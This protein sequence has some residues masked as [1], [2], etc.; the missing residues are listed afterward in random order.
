MQPKD[1]G[2]TKTTL[3]V[4]NRALSQTHGCAKR[5]IL[6]FFL[7]FFFL[8]LGKINERVLRETK[9]KHAACLEK[10]NTTRNIDKELRLFVWT[11]AP[12]SLGGRKLLT[13]LPHQPRRHFDFGT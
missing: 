9:K 5:C 4:T 7:V 3:C 13:W 6:C 12:R 1:K 11:P 8:E 2:K 10:R